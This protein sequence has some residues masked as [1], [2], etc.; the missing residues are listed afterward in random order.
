MS[1]S[2][3]TWRRC[4]LGAGKAQVRWSLIVCPKWIYMHPWRCSFF[5]K[6]IVQLSR[7]VHE[8]QKHPAAFYMYC[9]VVAVLWCFLWRVQ[10]RQWDG[11]INR[12][13]ITQ[14][15]RW[16]HSWFNGD[17]HNMCTCPL[18]IRRHWMVCRLRSRPNGRPWDGGV[19]PRKLNPHTIWEQGYT[20]CGYTSNVLH[21][22][23]LLLPTW[24][25]V[26]VYWAQTVALL[27]ACRTLAF[28]QCPWSGIRCEAKAEGLGTAWGKTSMR[29]SRAVIMASRLHW[30]GGDLVH[31]WMGV[32]GW[33]YLQW[34][35]LY[36]N[37]YT[38]LYQ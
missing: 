28:S 19:G 30:C 27:D 33:M 26:H 21:V 11:A 37:N 22:S 15:W 20:S 32:G 8:W 9:R 23:D 13:G 12:P 7:L 18:S 2:T 17:T 38:K 31:E 5:T 25:C 34:N 24:F 36:D 1:C 14:E 3:R 6:C 4:V 10:G 35:A 16:W 29:S